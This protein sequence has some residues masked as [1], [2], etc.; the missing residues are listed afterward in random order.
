MLISFVFCVSK[1][2]YYYLICTSKKPKI[3]VAVSDP[4]NTIKTRG[5]KRL[6]GQGR[7]VTPLSRNPDSEMPVVA[8]D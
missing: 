6:W 2:L 1:T 4:E 7:L 3:V 5:V 8:V